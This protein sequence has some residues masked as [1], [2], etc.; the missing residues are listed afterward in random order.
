LMDKYACKDNKTCP[1]TYKPARCEI[2][3]CPVCPPNQ[4]CRCPPQKTIGD[5]PINQHPD[6]KYYISREEAKQILKDQLNRVKPPSVPIEK[7]P[8]YRKLMDKYACK[9]NNTCPPTYR[10]SLC[11]VPKC[12]ACPPQQPC[13]CPPQQPCRCPPPKQCPVCPPQKQCPV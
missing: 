4:P 1:P 12:P 7:H 2:P 13:N 8:D 5:F 3:K 9:N 10:P 11:Q 6:F